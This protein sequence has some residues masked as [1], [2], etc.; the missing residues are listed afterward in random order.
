MEA[1]AVLYVVLQLRPES[2]IEFRD[3]AG[4]GD[5]QI[6]RVD[7][8]D[9]DAE[10]P[11]ILHQLHD[12]LGRGCISRPELPHRQEPVVIRVSRRERGLDVIRQRLRIGNVEDDRRAD[13]FGRW[14]R[15]RRIGGR[16]DAYRQREHGGTADR[17]ESS[18]GIHADTPQTWITL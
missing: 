2:G 4:D 17:K 13:C 10:R 1:L 12:L 11:Q 16:A 3:R 14:R 5:V 15:W 9:R 18:L 8:V 6:V 7:F